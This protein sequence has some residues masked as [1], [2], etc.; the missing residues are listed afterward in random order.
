MCR[1]ML[2]VCLPTVIGASVYVL[3]RTSTLLVFKCIEA[4]GL[5]GHVIALREGVSHVRLPEW[6]LYS[7][8]DGAWVYAT[9]MWMV[10]IWNGAPPW[11]WLSI[12]LVLAVGAEL[13]QA[14]GCVQG[15]Y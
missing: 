10:I 12:G 13:G 8:P 1:F 3:F 4:V 2:H 6:F 14:A 5:Y 7:F 11:P 15:T 9:T